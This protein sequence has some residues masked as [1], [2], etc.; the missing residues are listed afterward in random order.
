MRDREHFVYVTREDIESKR[1]YYS[2]N[3]RESERIVREA[4]RF[5]RETFHPT[6]CRSYFVRSLESAIESALV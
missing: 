4:Q 5:A 6:A 3:P 2:N 1:A